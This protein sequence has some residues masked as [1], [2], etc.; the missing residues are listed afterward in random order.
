ML[1]LYFAA[2]LVAAAGGVIASVIEVAILGAVI[3]A[4]VFKI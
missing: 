1:M 3:V 4:S 2:V